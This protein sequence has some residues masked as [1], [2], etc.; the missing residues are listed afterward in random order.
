[1][2]DSGGF[3]VRL[4]REGESQPGPTVVLECGIAGPTSA[5]WAW[6]RRSVQRFAPVVAYD[7]AGLGRSE[8]G[9]LPRDGRT[10]AREL[11][12]A[13]A[14]AGVAPPY[15]FVGH[16][17]GGLLSRI[18]TAEFPADVAGVVLVDSTHPQ[19][20]KRAGISHW[21]AIVHALL[22]VAPIASELGLMRAIVR[23]SHVPPKHLPEPERT[24][25]VEFLSG[26]RHWRGVGR[27]FDSW[28]TRTAPQAAACSSLGSRP[29]VVITAG[30]SLK[31]W[32]GWTGFQ[33][34]LARLSTDAEHRVFPEADH[35]LLVVDEAQ[36]RV[37]VQAVLDVVTAIRERRPLAA[38]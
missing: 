37:V 10:I 17:F 20:L 28:G 6:V 11:R 38:R 3:R 7:R 22:K 1:M 27:E 21:R 25:Q 35:A 12:L 33:A 9:P 24:E 4:V 18:F 26:A 23:L 34:E 31:Q 15:V 16:S 36:S 14:N 32:P 29:L 13:L 8:P 5:S 2:V 19:Q 30:L